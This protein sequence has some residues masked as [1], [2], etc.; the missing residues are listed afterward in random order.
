MFFFLPAGFPLS[1]CSGLLLIWTEMEIC[2][3]AL[4][5]VPSTS[6]TMWDLQAGGLS[7]CVFA[8][9][10]VNF[11]WLEVFPSHRDA[12]GRSNRHDSRSLLNAGIIIYSLLICICI[13]VHKHIH[14]STGGYCA[15][16]QKIIS[17]LDI[18]MCERSL[19]PSMGVYPHPQRGVYRSSGR[20]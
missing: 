20:D 6:V 11:I 13:H 4:H 19:S 5:H 7:V 12:P 2:F 9:P 15:I 16:S 17:A 8:W 1:Y 3:F 18:W 14:T 10:C